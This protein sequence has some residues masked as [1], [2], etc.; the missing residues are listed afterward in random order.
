MRQLSLSGWLSEGT[1]VRDDDPLVEVATD[2]VD[3]EVP[4]PAG[5]VIVSI[6]AA[7]GSVVRVGEIIAAIETTG[8]PV[9]GESEK[10]DTEVKRIRETID[11]VKKEKKEVEV[12]SHG[13]KSRTPSGKF[14][15]PL[16]GSIA[17]REGISH[18]DLDKI[19]GTGMDGRITR[20][21]I[22]RFINDR[23]KAAEALKDYRTFTEKRY[24]FKK[25]GRR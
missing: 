6:L 5:G 1:A 21:D 7:E 15:S 16:V 19:A 9:P 20:D 13:L 12:V 17:A 22:I 14:I 11:E 8:E 24:C 4:S 23:N 10:I 2:K 18:G 25:S 3:S